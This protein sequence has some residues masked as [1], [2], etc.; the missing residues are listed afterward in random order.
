LRPTRARVAPVIR[1]VQLGTRYLGFVSALSVVVGLTFKSELL[2][3]SQV[4]YA[5]L[6]LAAFVTGGLL[7]LH[8]R[9]QIPGW[10]SLDHYVT[11]VL[12]IVAGSAFSLMAPDWRQ[13]LLAMIGMGAV[14]F[15]SSYVDLMRGL[16]RVR[17]LHRFL[18]DAT[19][20]VTLLALIYLVL[21][22]ELPNALKFTSVFFV[23]LFCAYRSNRLATEREGRA[24]LAAF[25]TAGTVAFGAF[26]MVTY[27]NQD[28]AYVA[29]VLSFA[30]YAYQGFIVHTL[31]DSLTRRIV[32]EY[33]LFALICIYLVALGL[34]RR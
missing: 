9:N 11:P 24:I 3:P 26:G 23:A 8:G 4:W 18:R 13:H 17:P 12:A 28:S 15:S 7:F 21:Q 20:F 22:S 14:I 31:D 25:L 6:A 30:W 33:G 27:L 29:V 32:F 10:R 1:P 16:G 2:D 34:L 5:T 19:T